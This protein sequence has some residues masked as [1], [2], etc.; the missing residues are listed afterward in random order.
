MKFFFYFHLKKFNNTT[1][2]LFIVVS[3]KYLN[4]YSYSK[5]CQEEIEGLTV[6]GL[7]GTQLVREFGSI[8]YEEPI[9]TKPSVKRGTSYKALLQGRCTW[10]IVQHRQPARILKAT[11]RHDF[12][13]VLRKTI[14]R[15]R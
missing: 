9:T 8:V 6:V 11:V 4:V 14:A 15:A 2:L 12:T 13:P 1:I 7:E 10:G 3:S 5:G